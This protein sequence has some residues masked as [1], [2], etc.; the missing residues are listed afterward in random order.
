MALVGGG[1]KSDG[2]NDINFTYSSPPTSVR[3]APL[4]IPLISVTTS[5][6]THKYTPFETVLVKREVFFKV[7]V[8][9]RDILLS[10]LS[11]SSL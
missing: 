10:V 6:Y 7:T 8:N 9:E 11:R 5:N 1:G 4:E 3:T 2:A